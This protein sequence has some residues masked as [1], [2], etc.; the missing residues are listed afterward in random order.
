MTSNFSDCRVIVVLCFILQLWSLHVYHLRVLLLS[1]C[2][3]MIPRNS[4]S[5]SSVM[6]CIVP[7][8]WSINFQTLC[9]CLQFEEVEGGPFTAT[10]LIT[11]E[12]LPRRRTPKASPVIVEGP[13]PTVTKPKASKRSS[14]SSAAISSASSSAATALLSQ[15][16]TTRTSV[17]TE[18][19]SG[20]IL[21]E[22]LG[23]GGRSS[24]SDAD[25]AR[26]PSLPS[27]TAPSTV[28]ARSTIGHRPV[29]YG[30]VPQPPSEDASDSD[31]GFEQPIYINGQM[32]MKVDESPYSNPKG[33][34]HRGAAGYSNGRQL[35]HRQ[36]SP[37][38]NATTA[39][40]YSNPRP[41]VQAVQASHVTL[42]SSVV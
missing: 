9:Q 26:A 36:P 22:A 38:A 39:S 41:A 11:G 19:V 32:Y 3:S 33:R 15:A 37:Y 16:P 27:T 23:T 18:P 30:N 2:R 7:Y 40:P 4:S 5:S 10:N 21:S 14:T 35:L 29:S 34:R 17:S 20:S 12:V 42:M 25:S 1:I 31:D 24:I 28:G 6:S 8:D 13:R